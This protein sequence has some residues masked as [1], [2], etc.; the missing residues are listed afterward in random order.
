MNQEEILEHNIICPTDKRT[1]QAT[2]KVPN[3]TPAHK[4]FDG[5]KPTNKKFSVKSTV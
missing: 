5:V 2:K 4:I 3:P 1:E